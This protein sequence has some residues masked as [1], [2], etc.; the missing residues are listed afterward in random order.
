MDI[1]N[2]TIKTEIF[3][4]AKKLN[5][6]FSQVKAEIR[7]Y[8]DLS[9]RIDRGEMESAGDFIS[10]MTAM[11]WMPIVDENG[12]ITELKH[13]YES[14]AE[15]DRLFK[16][17][18]PFVEIGSFIQYDRES[19]STPIMVK[20]MFLNTGILKRVWCKEYNDQTS[21]DELIFSE[22]QSEWL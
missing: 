19:S 8:E 10:L 11:R 4:P 22:T 2:N 16:S 5:H 20:Y 7:Q 12:N 17:I 3:I 9:Y 6:A 15:E 18:S 13:T 1:E 21:K 14:V